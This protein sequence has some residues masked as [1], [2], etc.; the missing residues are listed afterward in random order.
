M[1]LNI[2]A[3]LHQNN[4]VFWEYYVFDGCH[5]L[6][7][8]ETGFGLVYLHININATRTSKAAVET[9]IGEPDRDVTVIIIFLYAI[10]LLK[11]NFWRRHRSLYSFD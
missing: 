6:F 2:E 5:K 7:I 9:E 11:R 4:F 10:A 1:L 3:V 8:C